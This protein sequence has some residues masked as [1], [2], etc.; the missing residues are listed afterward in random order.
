GLFEF[1]AG[2]LVVVNASSGLSDNLVEALLMDREGKLW[3]GTHGGLNRI[4]LEKVSVLSHDKG[5][6][7]GAVQGLAEVRPGVIWAA[8]PNGLYQWDGRMFR[9]LMLG[10]VS[11]REPSV[12]VLLADRNGSC[13]AGGPDGLLH[14]RNPAAAE[15]TSA[16]IVLT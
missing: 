7:Y 8:Q 15:A 13:W 9:R 1:K 5:L 4:C 16:D 2:K 12:A 11:S 10:Q 14:F 6:D 3:V